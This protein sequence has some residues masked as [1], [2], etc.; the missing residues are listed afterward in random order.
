MLAVSV[1]LA[2]VAEPNKL[3]R[4][5]TADE[6]ALAIAIVVQVRPRV[7]RLRGPI[8]FLR[9]GLTLLKTK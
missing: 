4:A 5:E 3:P 9:R 6:I 1:G 7:L 2:L 8:W